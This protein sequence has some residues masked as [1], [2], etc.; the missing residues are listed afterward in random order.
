MCF[1]ENKWLEEGPD[2]FR[3]VFYKQYI[4]NTFFIYKYHAS[5]FLNYFNSQHTKNNFT[6]ETEQN[7]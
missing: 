3:P 1:C 4:D 2:D 6:M 5:L 7:R